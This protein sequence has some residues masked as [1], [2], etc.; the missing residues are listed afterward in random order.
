V[1]ERLMPEFAGIEVGVNTYGHPARP[2]LRALAR[3]H[4]PTY[5]TDRDGTVSLAVTGGELHVETER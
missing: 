4:V 1:L 2:T 5:R 3:A